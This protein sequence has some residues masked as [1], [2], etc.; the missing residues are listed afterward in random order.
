M[1][2]FDNRDYEPAERL[3]SKE[4]MSLETRKIKA[5]INIF[6]DA[7]ILERNATK[8]NSSVNAHEMVSENTLK[9][10]MFRV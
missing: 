3:F 8:W 1:R 2:R 10:T 6:T 9:N 7:D 5:E 4:D